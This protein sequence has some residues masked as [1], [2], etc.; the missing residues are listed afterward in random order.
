MQLSTY[1][2]H[3]D[4]QWVSQTY[5]AHNQNAEFLLHPKSYPSVLIISVNG[6]FI[7]TVA[8]TEELGMIPDSSFFDTPYPIHQNILSTLALRY[9]WNPTTFLHFIATILVHSTTLSHLDYCKCRDVY[10]SFSDFLFHLE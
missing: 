3:L 1:H 4:I 8:Q 2:L 9:I 7:F 5:H 6:N 10:T